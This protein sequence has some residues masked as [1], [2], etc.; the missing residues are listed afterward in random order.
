MR[1]GITERGDP[2]IDFSWVKKMDKMDG[3]I[4][5]T[6]N[7]TDKV[8]EEA[9]P[10]L[11]KMIFHVTCTGYGQTVLEPNI[12]EVEKQL[13]Q[14]QKLL[15]AGVPVERVVIR[16]DPIIPTVKGLKRAQG[17]FEKAAQLGFVRFRVSLMDAYAH[18]GERFR[19]NGLNHPYGGAFTAPRDMIKN[20]DELFAKVKEL[21]PKITIE[22][23]AEGLLTNT[24]RT[25]C[26]SHK[27][28]SLLGLSMDNVD[29]AGYQRKGCLCCS[30]KTELL[31]EKKQ[32][33]YKCLYCYWKN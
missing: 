23:C 11:D 2:S 16:I 27:D 22:S 15:S 21:Y 13:Q 18:V 17:V 31:A 7:L 8:I 9:T 14:A 12:P 20:A 25:G 29:D 3:V 24:L 26:V 30:A 5:I 33:P 4:L 10:Y 32:C 28:F 6:K 1:I 19:E